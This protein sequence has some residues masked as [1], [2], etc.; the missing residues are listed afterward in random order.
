[1]G[2]WQKIKNAIV[3]GKADEIGM[4]TPQGTKAITKELI[5]E[6]NKK[7]GEANAKKD[8]QKIDVEQSKNLIEGIDGMR[9]KKSATIINTARQNEADK[10]AIAKDWDIVAT[11]QVASE[12][13]QAV[14]SGKK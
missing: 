7:V 1:M 12:I 11:Q 6:L 2:T 9:V 13:K 5:G 10:A 14:N 8:W 4:K 3:G